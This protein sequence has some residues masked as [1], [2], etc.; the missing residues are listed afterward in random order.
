MT[1][2]RKNTKFILDSKAR[3][4]L[5]ENI[6]FFHEQSKILNETPQ[7]NILVVKLQ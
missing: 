7:K 6:G 3:K 5:T 1:E 4:V 2:Y